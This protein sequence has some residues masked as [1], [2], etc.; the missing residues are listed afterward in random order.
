MS[1]IQ[2]VN[3]TLGAYTPALAADAPVKSTASFSQS[4]SAAQTPASWVTTPEASRASRPNITTFMD[5]TGLHFR[6]ACSMIFGVV[7]SNTDVRDWSA[8]MASDDPVTAAR[9]ATAQMYGRTDITPRSNASYMNNNNTLAREGNFAI[10][11]L[12]DGQGQVTEQGL[13]LID[14]QGLVLRDAG[15]SAK[16]IARNA[17]LFGFDT[18]PLAKLAKSASSVSESLGQAVTQASQMNMAMAST[19]LS[20]VKTS[21][22]ADSSNSVMSLSQAVSRSQLRSQATTSS[23]GIS[24][25]ALEQARSS[26]SRAHAATH[27]D[28]ASYLRSLFRA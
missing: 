2:A 14:A 26:A 6:D 24:A 3:K 28:T 15:G 22:P 16:K 4:L 8:I 1:N 17:W 20:A 12:K 23:D 7:G 25:S 27:V 21:L 19:R 10:R 11:Q 5:R 18:Q 13:K 9:Q